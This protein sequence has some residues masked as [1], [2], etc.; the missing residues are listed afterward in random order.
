MISGHYAFFG[1][2][3][4]GNQTKHIMT[5]KHF[6]DHRMVGIKENT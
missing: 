4:K 6:L 2:M 5:A 3:N 1:S